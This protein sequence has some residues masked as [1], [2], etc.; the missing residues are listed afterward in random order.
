MP[1][2]V[3]IKFETKILSLTEVIVF[4]RN[5][6]HTYIYTHIHTHIHTYIHTDFFIR[7]LT[8]ACSKTDFSTKIFFLRWILKIFARLQYT[9]L[10][11]SN[12]YNNSINFLD[13]TIK[14]N[15]SGII[16]TNWYTKEVSSQRYLNFNSHTHNS[17]K[18][19]VIN[20]LTQN[21]EQTTWKKLKQYKSIHTIYNKTANSSNSFLLYC[22]KSLWQTFPE[23]F[24]V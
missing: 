1:F 6:L 22:W 15:D 19:S 9:Y 17:Y 18:K 10:I 20:S 5:G 14:Y 4:T 13:L 12:R 2:Y 24:L 11:K 23:A 16:N 7:Y 21:I 8:S 3:G